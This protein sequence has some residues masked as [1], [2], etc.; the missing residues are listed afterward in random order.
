MTHADLG[1]SALALLYGPAG[2]DGET[3][4]RYSSQP[5]VKVVQGS[6]QST[7]GPDPR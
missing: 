4:L 1:N 6:V 5:T 2:T 7:L 3:V